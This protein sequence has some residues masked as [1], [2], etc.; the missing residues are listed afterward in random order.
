MVPWWNCCTVSRWPRCRAVALEG[1][2]LM[3][4]QQEKLEC[5]E[6]H[7]ED[8]GVEASGDTNT[9]EPCRARLREDDGGNTCCWSGSS[10]PCLHC[11]A[12]ACRPPSIGCMRHCEPALEL[13][14]HCRVSSA[15]RCCEVAR[16]H[17]IRTM[18]KL[19]VLRHRWPCW[20]SPPHP[21]LVQARCAERS[22]AL[23]ATPM[24][25]GKPEA[26]EET[27][28]GDVRE[29]S[30]PAWPCE[31]MHNTC[32]MFCLNGVHMTAASKNIPTDN[33]VPGAPSML[34]NTV[35]V[36]PRRGQFSVNLDLFSSH[37]GWVTME[38]NW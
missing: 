36:D 13:Q 11:H 19:A 20:P 30:M 5:V 25:V 29:S 28:M 3:Q 12:S 17:P 9:F 4:T 26:W 18:T 32:S 27:Q 35:D 1:A 37:P 10:W 14:H 2:S 15:P 34:K 6:Q 8:V 21:S 23:L 38:I 7:E 33:E 31:R 24:R 16:R 22:S